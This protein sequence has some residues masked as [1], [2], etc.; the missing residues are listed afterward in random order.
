MQ[1]KNIFP[2]LF[3]ALCQVTGKVIHF[4]PGLRDGIV[5]YSVH[6]FFC[7]NLPLQVLFVASRPRLVKYLS[8][9][10]IREIHVCHADK[11]KGLF[12]LSEL[13]RQKSNSHFPEG[14]WFFSLKKKN[15]FINPVKSL[16]KMELKLLK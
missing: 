10:T 7:K 8:L 1:K 16:L 4:I 15:R 13:V 2:A 5:A 6:H 12:G 11:T 9:L 14:Q 3:S